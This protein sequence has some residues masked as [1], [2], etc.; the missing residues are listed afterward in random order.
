[1]VGDH[2]GILCAVVFYFFFFYYFDVPESCFFFELGQ[3][4]GCLH[5]FFWG[6]GGGGGGFLGFFIWIPFY[7]VIFLHNS[8]AA[9]GA[10]RWHTP[11]PSR[12]CMRFLAKIL[13]LTW[14]MWSSVWHMAGA[15]FWYFS[16]SSSTQRHDFLELY[17]PKWGPKG[18]T[19]QVLDEELC[20]AHF[21]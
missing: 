15:V 13:T 11:C 9:G 20:V 18:Q 4:P 10:P 8:V 19:W 6:G 7:L 3:R 17:A 14:P 12:V 2:M 21:L 1:M 16:S 5:S